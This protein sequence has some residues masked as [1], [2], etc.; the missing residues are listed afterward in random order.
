MAAWLL[1]AAALGLAILGQIYFF[2]RR[3]YGWD[4]L[5]FHVMAALCFVLAW[6]LTKPAKP[7]A[8][9][10][11]S[12]RL[13]AWL[14]ARTVPAALLAL[15][16]FFSLLAI[17]LMQ[18]RTLS[19]S[20]H[21]AVLFW[22]LG[23]ACVGLA[24]L[25]PVSRVLT[26]FRTWKE[27]LRAVR[28]DTVLEAATVAAL[29]LL[30]LVLRVSALDSVPYTLGGDEAWHGLLARQVLAGQVRNP[31][32]MGYMSMPTAFYW[33]LSWSLWLVGDTV[34]GLRFPA[35]LVGTITVPI[36]YLFARDLW[37]RRTALLS[38]IFVAAYDYHIH[39]SRLGANNVWD[40]LFVV[41]TLW[42]LDRGLRGNARSG[43]A[44][45]RKPGGRA[46]EGAILAALP[47]FPPGRVGD[48]VEHALLHRRT[49]AARVGRH[50][51]G[52]CLAAAAQ[53]GRAAG[54]ARGA[55][56]GGL[57]DGSWADAELRSVSP[58]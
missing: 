6:H 24:A 49:A 50:L 34:T 44:W 19:Q 22:G 46:T 41:L 51:C 55:A 7:R 13:G 30:A 38:S 10:R 20:T 16:A 15:G 23:V 29:T 42:A 25:W 52:L 39:F 26:S 37:G 8:T 21:D 28:R 57:C 27:S 45:G 47:V 17:F 1:L 32:T 14:R 3:E 2:Q 33:P 56:R 43:S 35:A 48:G 18:D 40:P 11:P 54:P 36:L 4:G 53:A 9:S 12:L 58:R 31:F 5:V